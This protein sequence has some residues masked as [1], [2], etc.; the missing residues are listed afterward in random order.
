[1]TRSIGYDDE[2]CR[3]FNESLD[4]EEKVV[5]ASASFPRSRILFEMDPELYKQALA[6]FIELD[7]E[8]LKQTVF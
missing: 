1:M 6:D 2:K 3:R 7:F 5:I 8:D 4:Q